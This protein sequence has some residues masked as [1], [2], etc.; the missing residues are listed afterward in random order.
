MPTSSVTLFKGGARLAGISYSCGEAAR[1]TVA[2]SFS[3]EAGAHGAAS[4][5]N[6]VVLDVEAALKRN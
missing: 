1:E 3:S 4:I 5:N 2:G 6:G